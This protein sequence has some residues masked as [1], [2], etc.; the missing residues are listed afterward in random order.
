M[1]NF[2]FEIREDRDFTA[3]ERSNGTMD[4]I[5]IIHWHPLDF[6]YIVPLDPDTNRRQCIESLL[7]PLDGAMTPDGDNV[8][9]FHFDNCQDVLTAWLRNIQLLADKLVPNQPFLT[10][11]LRQ[12]ARAAELT[13]YCDTYVYDPNDGDIMSVRKYLSC[14]SLCKDGHKFYIGKIWDYHV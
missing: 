5:Q 6:D 8:L 10:G 1:H 2:I 7:S 11:G 9:T 4:E 3:D 12:L 13:D 14:C